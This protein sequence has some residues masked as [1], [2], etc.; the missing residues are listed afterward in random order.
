MLDAQLSSH[1]GASRPAY[2]VAGTIWPKEVSAQFEDLYYFD[3]T[4]D[5][6]FGRLDVVNNT[7]DPA[8]AV[9]R[10]H[11]A[12]MEVSIA[13]DA[14]HDRTVAVG[15]CADSTGVCRLK[16]SAALTKQIDAGW[17]AGSNAG[18]M[19]S[20]AVGNDTWY[21]FFVIKKDSDGTIDAGFDTS[22]S[23]AN[24][25]AGYTSYRRLASFRT[26]GSANIRAS[27]QHGDQFLWADPPLDVD[28]SDQSTTTIAR[29]LSVPPDFSVLAI[30]NAYQAQGSGACV[31][32]REPDRNDEAPS[33]SAAPLS[34]LGSGVAAF[35]GQFTIRT[36]TS[37]Q[38]YTR[39][40]ISS[41]VLRIATLGY[42][43]RRGRDD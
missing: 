18:G 39:S 20:G 23:A 42:W 5:I 19:F 24:K 21:H 31:D 22:I 11:L 15:E 38:I 10:G 30:I 1:K 17:A 3:G 28:V 8:N 36:N 12:G 33:V 26:D 4:D 14:D 7:F 13:A 34:T 9:P 37:G 43:D 25:P 32:I 2:A 40:I 27:V 6:L 41:T 35:T 29:T 16:L